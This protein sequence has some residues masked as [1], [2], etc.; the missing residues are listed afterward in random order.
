MMFPDIEM[1]QALKMSQVDGR[2]T[3]IYG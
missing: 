2:L 3:F 1:S